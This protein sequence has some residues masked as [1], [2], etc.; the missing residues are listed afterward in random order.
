MTKEKLIEKYSKLVERGKNRITEG[1][2]GDFVD[3]LQSQLEIDEII[4][5]ALEKQIPKNPILDIEA[6]HKT[7]TIEAGRALRC[8]IC[9]FELFGFEIYCPYCGQKLT[10]A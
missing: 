5:E 2:R 4:L 6:T 10:E 8:S 3:S 1:V 7:Y 9:N